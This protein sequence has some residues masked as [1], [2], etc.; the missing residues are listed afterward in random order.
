M[1]FNQFNELVN[2]KKEERNMN[3]KTLRELIENGEME[4]V[5]EFLR[6]LVD[7]KVD[8]FRKSCTELDTFILDKYRNLVRDEK[9]Y[10]DCI[11]IPLQPTEQMQFIKSIAKAYV[12]E[13]Y[14]KGTLEYTEIE[15]E[16]LE[17]MYN[18]VKH[19]GKDGFLEATLY[20]LRQG[21]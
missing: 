9:L 6:K 11:L 14:E 12:K 7:Q 21:A 10:V 20:S 2:G 19:Y 15:K 16:N 3:E 1:D 5:E 13:L 17:T 4:K 8:E 18:V